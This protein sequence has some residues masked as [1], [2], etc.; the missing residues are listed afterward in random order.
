MG[1]RLATVLRSRSAGEW[2]D[3]ILLVG[4]HLKAGILYAMG[5]DYRLIAWMLMGLLALL[6]V[7]PILG[8][9]QVINECC[10]PLFTQRRAKE[11]E[12]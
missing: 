7:L 3:G 10:C 12:T 8:V 4:E 11:K 6:A 5:E 2:L 9:A 1:Q